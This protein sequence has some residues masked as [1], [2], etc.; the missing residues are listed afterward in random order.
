[1]AGN[2]DGSDSH[3]SSCHYTPTDSS[4]SSK[5]KSGG[6]AGAVTANSG[7][8]PVRLN[9]GK[10]EPWAHVPGY[11]LSGLNVMWP[12]NFIWPPGLHWGWGGGAHI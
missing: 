12:L 3:S 10:V 11:I 6:S 4:A 9:M 7:G 8:S 2:L 5:E 1:V